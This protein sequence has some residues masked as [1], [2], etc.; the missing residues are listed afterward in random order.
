[1][2]KTLR[3]DKVFAHKIGTDS[4]K[5]ILKYHEK[6]E[7]FYTTVFKS[8]SKKF[9]IIGTGSTLTNYYQ[10]L[11]ADQPDADFQEFT[12][13]KEGLEYSIAHF[14]NKFY[15]ITNWNALNF[16]LMETDAS[17]TDQKNW[18][19]VIPHRD[20]V[21]IEGIEVFKNHLV[22]EERKNGLPE[23]R[24]IDHKDGTEH[25][26]QFDEPAY[27]VYPSINP[28]FDTNTFRF[29]Y[30]SLTTPSTVYDYD[31][32]TRKKQQLKQ[33]EVVGGYNI[34]NY[35]TERHYAEAHNGVQIPISLVY[36][37]GF[38]PNGQSPLLLYGY[39]SYGSTIDPYFSSVRLS[40]LDRG[41]VF[42]IAH[43]RG[44][45][46]LGRQWYEDGKMF[47]KKKHIPRFYCMCEISDR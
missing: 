36:K 6:D 5:D 7:A 30:S 22:L 18:Q 9:I 42:A 28:E 3:S 14:E 16:K 2:K 43:V 25:Y 26:M 11:R 13:R 37:T 12:A 1:M 19:E 32:D 24:I 33:Q 35:K 4:A 31:M 38:E 46:T 44:G 47:K 15:I 40:L 27:T 34:S 8:K 17:S 39:G 29:G 21:F 10:L 45:Q 23:L 20:D 41:F